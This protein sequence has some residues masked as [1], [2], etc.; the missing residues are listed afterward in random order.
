MLGERLKILRRGKG[1][2][3]RQLADRMFLSVN[4]IS[5]YERD[6]NTPDDATK[7]WLARF[8][9][10]SLDYLMGLIDAPIPL[11]RPSPSAGAEA[12]PFGRRDC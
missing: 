10:V 11:V 5:S 3:Q 4:T 7:I 2:T 1:L 6:I 8:F 9:N 12:P